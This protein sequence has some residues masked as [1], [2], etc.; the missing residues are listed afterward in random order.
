ME[1]LQ[2][3]TFAIV[4]VETTGTS[5]TGDRVIELGI[6]RV[7]NAVVVER[8]TTLLNPESYVPPQIERITG[9]QAEE[10]LTAP[11]FGDVRDKVSELLDGAIFVAHNARFDYGFIKN[12]FK[13]EGLS[14]S[15]KCLCTVRLSRKMFPEYKKHD[16]STIIE[17]YNFSCERRH[18]AQDDAEVLWDFMMHIHGSGRG[19]EM[20]EA[21]VDITRGSSIPQFLDEKSVKKLPEAPGVYI[22]YGEHDEVL[23]VG[24][25][26][27]I[28]TRVLSHFSSDH[29]T[30]KEMHLCQEVRRIESTETA[31]ELSA[32]L[33]E[34]QLVKSLSPHYNR[35]L[36]RRSELVIANKRTAGGYTTI[37]LAR[38][39]ALLPGDYKNVLGIFK[40]I[41]QAKSFLREA[42][43]EFD[44]CPKLLGL[45]KCSG[46][47]FSS[48]L[49][50]CKG[51]CA[52]RESTEAYNERVVE[53]FKHRRL[54][55]WPFAG[56]ILIEEK[57]ESETRSFVLDNWCLVADVR[58]T[59]DDTELNPHA[60][61]FDYDAYKIF[62]RYIKDPLNKKRIK[63]LST[64]ELEAIL[65]EDEETVILE[66]YE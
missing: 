44:L 6:L 40:S 41:G 15:A 30:T 27:S 16:L 31:G 59:D 65:K 60:S 13:R 52:K 53:A 10:L 26:K 9:I 48:Q 2:D 57:G 24:K 21:I 55:A 17:R 36:R 11:T 45:E 61:H 18:R 32:L 46:A 58:A 12:E 22:F 34:S 64:Q 1:H 42:Q 43:M 5:P 29:A 8:F 7:V 37:E 66:A 62:L 20:S 35:V 51:A 38:L 63:R 50:K 3:K 4:D 56:A 28:R 23:Y 54:R 33:L 19:K 47:C 39:R 14:F 49:R 25:S